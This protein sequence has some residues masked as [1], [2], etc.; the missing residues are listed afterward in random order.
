M[1]SAEQRWPALLKADAST[2]VTTCSGSAEES[3]TIAFRPPVSAMNGTMG[4]SRAASARLMASAVSTDP[5]KATPATR[6]SRT[7]AA[8]TVSPVPATTRSA[9]SGTP[10]SWKS[11]ATRAA[12]RGV[13]SAGF[14][15]TAFPA[16]SAALT[17]PVKMASGKFHGLIHAKTPRPASSSRFDSP[18]GP[19]NCRGA[20]KSAR[21]CAA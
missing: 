5:V 13:C 8:P 12:T 1:R 9:S 14:A 11:A 7:S 10:A 18:A 6:G 19:G 17:W 3:I 2:S 4:P 16:A 20:A 21:A 15:T